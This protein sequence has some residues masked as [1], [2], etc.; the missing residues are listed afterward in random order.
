MVRFAKWGCRH[1]GI[2]RDPTTVHVV[3]RLEDGRRWP[4]GMIC[5]QCA[6]AIGPA[7]LAELST[8]YIIQA[9]NW[10]QLLGPVTIVFEHLAQALSGEQCSTVL[11][12][13]ARKRAIQAQLLREGLER[14]GRWIP[15]EVQFSEYVAFRITE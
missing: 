13:L 9:L 6:A 5:R 1:R 2:S 14:A 8:F 11:D 12:H 7:G 4:G 15:P 3:Y 10:A